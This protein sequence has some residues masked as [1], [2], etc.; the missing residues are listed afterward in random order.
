MN[1]Q[2]QYRPRVR[3]SRPVPDCFS[4]LKRSPDDWMEITWITKPSVETGNDAFLAR[5]HVSQMIW[6]TMIWC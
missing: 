2:L 4:E 5:C 1:A 6:W 3:P